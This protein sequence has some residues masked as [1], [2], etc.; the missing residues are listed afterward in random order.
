MARRLLDLLDVKSDEV[1]WDKI[2]I[3]GAIPDD[4]E[5]L[6]GLV[7]YIVWN[8]NGDS[9]LVHA[10]KDHLRGVVKATDAGTVEQS[11]PEIAR[12][13]VRSGHF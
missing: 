5:N 8:G 2:D 11:N 1:A 10:Q 7:W 3:D 6:E 13:F 9:V 4:Y 12:R